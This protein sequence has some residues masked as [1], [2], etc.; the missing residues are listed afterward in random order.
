MSSFTQPLILEALATERRGRGEF[1]TYLPFT[2]EV[3]H[4]GSGDKVTVPSGYNTDLASIPWFARPFI[5]IAGRMAKPA[6]V[7]DWLVEQND[8]R[9]N[10]I[11]DE[12]LKVAGVGNP[13]RWLMVT[14]VRIWMP[15]RRILW[16]AKFRTVVKVKPR[17]SL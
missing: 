2:Y 8:P 1:L 11:F 14:A 7:H 9:A 15:I 4:L 5:P 6:L 16:P 13:T 3:G 10:E 12:A 17:T